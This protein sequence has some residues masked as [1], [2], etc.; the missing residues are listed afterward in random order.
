MSW[1][2]L[3]TLVVPVH[4]I[5]PKSLYFRMFQFQIILFISF[6]TIM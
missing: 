5:V 4:Y 3:M 1:L 6:A 2:D